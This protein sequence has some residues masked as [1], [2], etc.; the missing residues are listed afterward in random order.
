MAQRPTGILAAPLRT[1]LENCRM[2]RHGYVRRC[3][4]KDNEVR[5]VAKS[6]IPRG[7]VVPMGPRNTRRGPICR[8][9]N[10]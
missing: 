4:V 7:G 5:R 9:F 2:F 3:L 8:Y 6:H 1:R 10:G